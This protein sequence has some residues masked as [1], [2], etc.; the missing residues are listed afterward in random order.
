MKSERIA[1]RADPDDPEDGDVT[2]SALAQALAERDARRAVGRPRGSG[3]S[4]K[5][6]VAIRLDND[7]LSH[8]RAAGPGWQTRVNEALRKAAGL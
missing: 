4:N 6:Q 5:S 3:R 8:F 1:L 7:V 2:E